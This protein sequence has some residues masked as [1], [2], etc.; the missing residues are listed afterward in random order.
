MRGLLYPPTL[1]NLVQKINTR[2]SL[3][4]MKRCFVLFHIIIIQ[5]LIFVFHED[6]V[7]WLLDDRRSRARAQIFNQLITF[8]T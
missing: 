2:K 6:A 5:L 8:I 4:D 1:F 3:K 7:R